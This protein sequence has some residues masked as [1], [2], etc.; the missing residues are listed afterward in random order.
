MKHKLA[1]NFSL[2]VWIILGL[3][4]VPL[5]ARS[6]PASSQ[7]SGF[8]WGELALLP[9]YCRD[10]QGIVY[11]NF[12]E[13]NE[14]P[15]KN[16]WLAILGPDFQHLHHY[17]YALRDV[18]RSTAAGATPARKRYL[19]LKALGDYNYVIRNCQPTLVIMPE[20]WLRLGELHLLMN[21]GG[22]AEAAFRNA[23]KLKADYWPAYVRWA[24]HLI[25]LKLTDPAREITR[26]GLLH[27]PDN[28]ELLK[29]DGQLDRL[30]KSADANPKKP[31]RKKDAESI[32]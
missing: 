20:V 21:N 15:R 29:L 27:S 14:S 30:K 23:R 11:S 17:C 3:C 22:E 31:P 9:E 26:E 24:Q 5:H 10:A 8:T 16:Y 1:T 32:K 18:L 4:C 6:Q 28:P 25:G 13:G 19:Y 2:A 7:P 12:G